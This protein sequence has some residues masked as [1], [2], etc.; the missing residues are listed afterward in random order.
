MID[1]R[2]LW[3]HDERSPFQAVASNQMARGNDS[4]EFP[5]E[6]SPVAHS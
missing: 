3:E 4:L 5:L 6:D 1:D 2:A